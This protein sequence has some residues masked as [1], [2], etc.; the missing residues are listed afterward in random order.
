M[1]TFG[2]QIDDAVRR[3]GREGSPPCLF[4]Q[5]AAKAVL[6]SGLLAFLA[7]DE[8]LGRFD[9]HRGGAQMSIANRR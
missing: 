6:R 1:D 5:N 4:S 2:R 7:N 9:H 3:G 8:G